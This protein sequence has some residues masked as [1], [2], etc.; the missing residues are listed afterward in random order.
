MK[1]TKFRNRYRKEP[2]SNFTFDEAS[3]LV[4]NDHPAMTYRLEFS[5]KSPMWNIEQERPGAKKENTRGYQTIA[6]DED[7]KKLFLFFEGTMIGMRMLNTRFTYNQVLM[8]WP[9]FEKEHYKNSLV[10]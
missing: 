7:I 9:A 8:L 2:L 5:E 3:K 1:R 10:K 4:D 6:K